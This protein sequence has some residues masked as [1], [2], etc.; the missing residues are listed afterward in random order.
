MALLLGHTLAHFFGNLKRNAMDIILFLINTP[1]ARHLA[2]INRTKH[3]PTWT[4]F[5]TGTCWH[6]SL[7]TC[8]HFLSGTYRQL[9]KI[10]ILPN[11]KGALSAKLSIF[12]RPFRV[13]CLY[14]YLVHGIG[15]PPPPAKETTEMLFVR[16]LV[17]YTWRCSP[18][19]RIPSPPPLH[20]V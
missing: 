17:K 13:W 9:I 15:P 20:T 10:V 7:G 3:A 12:I 4:G 14:S 6:A 8:S 11:K 1:I 16:N 5:C 18:H 2:A 19:K